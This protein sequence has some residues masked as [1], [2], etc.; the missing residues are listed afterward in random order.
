M[1]ESMPSYVLVI[2]KYKEDMSW[3]NHIR[4]E[5]CII[6]DKSPNPMSGSI[7]IPNIGM[8]QETYFRYIVDNYNNLPEYVIFLQGWPFDHMPNTGINPEN[9]QNYIDAAVSVK[10]NQIMGFYV[11]YHVHGYSDLQ[12]GLKVPQ[13]YEY[14]FNTKFPGKISFTSG[15]QYIIP[16]AAIMTRPLKFYEKIHRMAFDMGPNELLGFDPHYNNRPFDTNTITAAALERFF[17]PIFSPEIKI[18]NV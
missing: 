16:R 14:F 12:P 10:P 1:T 8:N 5:N 15:S 2:S 11:N 17:M 13:Y 4:K 9:F 7:P 18:N 3:L 6:Y